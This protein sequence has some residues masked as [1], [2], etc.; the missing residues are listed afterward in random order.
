MEKATLKPLT[1]PPKILIAWAEAIGGN[2]KIRD[3]LL[4][5]GYKELAMFTYAVRNKDDARQWLMDNGY[6]HLMAMIN[7]VE[8]N[9]IALKWLQRFN[10]TILEKMALSADGDDVAHQWLLHNGHKEFAYVAKKI[11]FVKD[12]IEDSN[13]D[14]HKISPD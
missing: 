11:E 14:P 2:V 1:Y 3:W 10:F 13:N 9:E 8:R 4:E 6:A 12:Q 5:N 7:G